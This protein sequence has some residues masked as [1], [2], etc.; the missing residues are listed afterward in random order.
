[1]IK[2]NKTY[3]TFAI[4]NRIDEE[5]DNIGMSDER[6]V[7]LIKESI[8]ETLKYYEDTFEEVEDWEVFE[9]DLYSDAKRKLGLE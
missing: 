9:S 5:F 8:D 2:I 7:E 4:A 1:M 3:Y 6:A